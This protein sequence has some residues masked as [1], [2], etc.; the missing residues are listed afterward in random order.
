MSYTPK[1]EKEEYFEAHATS[2]ISLS[3]S[4][5][6]L[7]SSSL[8]PTP[9]KVEQKMNPVQPKVQEPKV[10]EYKNEGERRLAEFVDAA[11]RKRAA[12]NG[13]QAQ[14]IR[15]AQ[16]AALVEESDKVNVF[17]ILQFLHRSRSKSRRGR[18]RSSARTRMHSSWLP[19]SEKSSRYA[20]SKSMRSLSRSL[21]R[22]R[23]SMTC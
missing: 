7:E 23:R 22:S 14:E 13:A 5:T 17:N 4:E 2:A 18:M 19:T 3:K 20:R 10:T 8:A 1:T 12:A 11:D 15:N 16:I 6:L 9:M 21:S